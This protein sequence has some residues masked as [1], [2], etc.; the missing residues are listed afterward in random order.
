M[1]VNDKHYLLNRDN[2][3]Q[4]IQMQLSQK[5]KTF[6][7]FRFA[8]LKSAIN[9]KHLLKK[10]TLIADVCP[11]IPA[12][13]N[14]VRS[15]SKKP[16]FRGPLESEH[17]KLAEIM[18]QSE[19]QKLYKIYQ[20]LWRQLH[21]KK[22]LLVILKILRQFVN[23]LTVDEK[24]YLLNRDNL[25]QPI[26]IQLSQKEKIFSQFFFAFLKSIL[27]FKHLPKKDDPHSWCISGNPGSEK[28]G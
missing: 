26:Q 17:G 28:Y 20:S 19:W 7:R 18:F 3:A 11:E 22:S 25:T 1:T 23:T 10:M 16:C 15:M 8:F 2:L 12:P 4:P 14:M 13:K 27:N 21:W 24:H 5:Q 6:S 9:Y